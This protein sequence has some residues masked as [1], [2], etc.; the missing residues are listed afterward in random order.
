MIK[1]L[2]SYLVFLSLLLACSCEKNDYVIYDQSFVTFTYTNSSS[3]SVDATGSFDAQYYLHLSS[4]ALDENLEVTVEVI[5]GDG[6]AEGV[7][8]ELITSGNVIFYP[9]IY[10]V[11]FRLRWL[12]HEIDGSKDNSLTLR[13]SGCSM[14][15]VI[16]GMP[17]PDESMREITIYKYVL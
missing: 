2:L 4:P 14:D 16:L 13:I 6:L 1:R 5:P 9:G 12:S 11:P 8:Y 7:D 15:E 3:V 17:G 10:D